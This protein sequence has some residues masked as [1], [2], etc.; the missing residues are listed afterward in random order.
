MEPRQTET[1]IRRSG[2]YFKFTK[3]ST[4][5]PLSLTKTVADNNVIIKGQ[6]N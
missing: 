5:G 3:Q 6:K 2:K 1:P 4:N